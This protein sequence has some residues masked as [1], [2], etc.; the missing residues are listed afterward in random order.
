MDSV[1][2][3]TYI[4]K[5][6]EEHRRHHDL[7]RAALEHRLEALNE[8]RDEVTSDRQQFVL[9]TT[10]D[11][12]HDKIVEDIRRLERDLGAIR[13]ELS[14]GKGRATAYAAVLTVF[15]IIVAIVVPLI[16]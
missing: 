11:A 2:L 14:A 16:F 3:H 5:L 4:E 9:T 1:D 12:K 8:L 15:L 13:E 10:Y 7:E 6:F